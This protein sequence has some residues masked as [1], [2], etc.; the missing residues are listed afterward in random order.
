LR[1]SRQKWPLARALLR[2]EEARGDAWKLLA[3]KELG[4]AKSAEA[5]LAE[6]REQWNQSC[7]KWTAEMEKHSKVLAAISSPERMEEM[8]AWFLA[9]DE[10]ADITHPRGAMASELRTLAAAMKEMEK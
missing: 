4:N 8:A 10:L 7:M 1:A 9:G 3:E 2:E 6:E 5:K